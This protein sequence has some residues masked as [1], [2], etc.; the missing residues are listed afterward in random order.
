MDASQILNIIAAEHGLCIEE[1]LGA[2]R[3]P[4][5]LRDAKVMELDET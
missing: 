1:N 3:R 5:T 2:S 4:C